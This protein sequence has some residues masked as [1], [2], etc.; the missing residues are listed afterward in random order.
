MSIFMHYPLFQMYV[1]ELG[2]SMETSYKSFIQRKTKK[3]KT[4]KN[5]FQNSGS[6]Q[7]LAYSDKL[8]IQNMYW[9][10]RNK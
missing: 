1:L 4:K 10:W 8:A 9:T 6:H 3:N 2:N 7:V 5:N